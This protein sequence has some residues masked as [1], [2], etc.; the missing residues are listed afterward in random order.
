MVS[1]LDIQKTVFFSAQL[2]LARTNARSIRQINH[3]PFTHE[4]E[5]FS[6]VT[7]EHI[8]MLELLVD[9]NL[10]RSLSA[11]RAFDLHLTYNRL[12]IQAQ[13]RFVNCSEIFSA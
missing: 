5:Y 4:E 11:I 2:T 1:T 3:F 13:N 7:S 12:A 6:F 10:A 9:R 8:A